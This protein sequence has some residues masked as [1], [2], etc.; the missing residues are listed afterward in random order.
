ML[1]KPNIKVS[2]RRRRILFRTNLVEYAQ[3]NKIKK[4]KNMHKYVCTKK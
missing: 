1:Y 4:N 2:H 3:L